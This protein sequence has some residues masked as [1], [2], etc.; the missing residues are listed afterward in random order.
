MLYEK[1]EEWFKVLLLLAVMLYLFL[2]GLSLLFSTAAL[3]FLWA[4]GL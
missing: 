1:L 4:F 2:G 3:Y